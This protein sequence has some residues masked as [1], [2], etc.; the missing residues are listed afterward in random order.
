MTNLV[1]PTATYFTLCLFLPIPVRRFDGFCFNILANILAGI[2]QPT[3][4]IEPHEKTDFPKDL[5][6]QANFDPHSRSTDP[7][8][9]HQAKLMRI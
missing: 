9:R 6:P 8:F 1:L 5:P 4:S 2:R 3:S 7:F